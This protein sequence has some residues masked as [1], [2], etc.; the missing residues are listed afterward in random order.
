MVSLIP[1]VPADPLDL[2]LQQ[3]LEGLL[4]QVVHPHLSDQ[5]DQGYQVGPKES[6]RKM[7]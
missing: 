1:F 5:E 6:K 2:Y 7:F 4:D 3:V